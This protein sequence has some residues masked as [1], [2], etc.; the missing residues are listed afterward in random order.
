MDNSNKI[1]PSKLFIH[2]VVDFRDELEEVREENFIQK[3][4]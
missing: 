3:W 4:F 2:S 1:A